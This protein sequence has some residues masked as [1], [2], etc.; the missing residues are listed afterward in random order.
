MADNRKEV[1]NSEANSFKN[2]VLHW[3]GG[4]NYPNDVDKEAYHFLVDKDGEVHYGIHKVEDNL[5]CTDGN[6]AA[7]CG[8]GNTGRI[9]VA[10]CGMMGFN[11][12][13]K[14]TKYPLTRKQFEAAFLLCAEL[15]KKYK[16]KPNQ[17]ITHA[18][19]GLKFP[20][21]SSKGKPDISYIPYLS[22]EG[23]EKI[24]SYIRNKVNWYYSKLKK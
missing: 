15:C 3:T 22:L 18:E 12:S 19:F 4:G 9:G 6:Y 13:M 23:V 21:T 7:H 16:L 14:F 24:G 8:G 20:N 17:V 2:I 10:L 11:N 1:I 5:D